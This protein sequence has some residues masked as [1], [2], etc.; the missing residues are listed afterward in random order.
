M[1]ETNLKALTER[2]KLT[3]TRQVMTLRDSKDAKV[4]GASYKTK[5]RRKWKVEK[6][7]KEADFRLKH[8]VILGVT[9]VGTQEVCRMEG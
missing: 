2:C 8:K 1:K 6:A 4:I 7:M 5:T 9:A 3:K